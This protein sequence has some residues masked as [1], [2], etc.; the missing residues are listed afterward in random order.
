[1]GNKEVR[2]RVLAEVDKLQDEIIRFLGHIVQTPSVVNEDQG[3][4]TRVIKAKYDSLGL[5]TDIVE[6]VKGKINVLGCWRGAGGDKSIGF[7]SHHDTM[8]VE[9]PSAWKH[10]PWG[11]EID[12]D[13]IM[14]G[15]G[16]AD[17]K[18]GI[19]CAVGAIQALQNAG[20]RLKG[21]V[22][23]LSNMGE[24]TSEEVGCKPVIQS[25]LF[26]VTGAV[27]GD[28][29]GTHLGEAAVTTHH[30]GMMIF[31][32][33]IKGTPGH[34][35]FPGYGVN[36]VLKTPKVI[37]ALVNLDI[38]HKPYKLAP[39]HPFAMIDSV[40]GGNSFPGFTPLKVDIGARL[41]LLPGQTEE[42]GLSSIKAGMDRL[43]KEDSEI[44]VDIN[45]VKWQPGDE[46]GDWPESQEL[47]GVIQ[48]VSKEIRG[49]EL[50]P[51]VMTAP[52]MA[53]YVQKAGIPTFVWSAARAGI[54]NPHRSNEWVAIK[55]VIDVTKDYA[56]IAMDYLGYEA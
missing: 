2:A 25:G 14:W 56:L 39:F 17:C 51:V 49:E 34:S 52:A 29:P 20:V 44:D 26:N 6:A 48:K 8:P 12:E 37:E 28:P 23:L 11:A 7:Y 22:V 15:E 31:T 24:V 54:C 32:V 21:D 46:I 10:D 41:H 9:E 30:L 35:L 1:M 36:A 40:N 16:I 27:Q 13:G 19:A 43:K 5:K 42:E 38:P 18:Q 45:V 3:P 33:S 53:H 50:T 55:D 4:V 47:L